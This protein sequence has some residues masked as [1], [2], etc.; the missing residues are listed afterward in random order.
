ML[1]SLSARGHRINF[2]NQVLSQVARD[3]ALSA[4]IILQQLSLHL[5]LQVAGRRALLRS[6]RASAASLSAELSRRQDQQAALRRRWD[7]IA[8]AAEREVQGK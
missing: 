4:H 7:V 5:T 1:C 3:A 6:L 8:G 2:I